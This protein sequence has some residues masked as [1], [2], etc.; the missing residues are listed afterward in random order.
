M[1]HTLMMNSSSLNKLIYGKDNYVIGSV[2]LC[3]YLLSFFQK[4]KVN[5]ITKK[6]SFMLLIVIS[7]FCSLFF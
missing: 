5:N 7:I 2:F 3:G 6:E 4:M 1:N